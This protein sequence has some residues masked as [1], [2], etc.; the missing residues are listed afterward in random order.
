L[1]RGPQLYAGTEDAPTFLTGTFALTQYRGAG[2][3]TLTIAAA[4]SPAPE[5]A[6]WALM[7]G[8]FGLIGGVM[9][10]RPRAAVNFG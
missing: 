9:R 3:Y 2:T 5:P 7:L 6:S 10:M 8:G 4:D 1:P